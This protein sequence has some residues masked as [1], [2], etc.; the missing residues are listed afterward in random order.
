MKKALVVVDYQNDFVDGALGFAGA[1]KLASGILALTEEFLS[2]G[3]P[4]L[5][6]LDTHTPDYLSTREGK[7]LPAPHCIRGTHGWRLYGPLA[8]Y[9]EPCGGV[10]LIEKGSFGTVDFDCLRACPPDR[11][12]LCGLV[13]NICVL[14]NAVTLQTLFPEAQLAVHA[15]LCGSFDPALHQKAL[16]VMAGLQ[17]RIL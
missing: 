16:D 13:T 1:E 7:N 11:I 15:S 17:V 2:Q 10:S 8:R 6:T 12:E 3:A 14:S 4:V 5:F 9:M